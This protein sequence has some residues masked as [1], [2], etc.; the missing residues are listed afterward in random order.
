MNERC[1]SEW[2][3]WNQRELLAALVELRRALAH[4]AGEL[5]ASGPVAGEPAAQATGEVPGAVSPPPAGF[6]SAL[7]TACEAFGLSSF[8]RGL[9]GRLQRVP[10]P[11]AA[12]TF[13][14][15]LGALPNPH[16]SALSPSGPLRRWR[17]IEAGSGDSLTASRLRIDERVLHFLCGVDAPDERLRGLVRRCSLPGPL[18]AAH[19]AAVA[20]VG[21]AWSKPAPHPL[22]QFLGGSATDQRGVAAAAA[23]SLG[24]QLSAM[25]AAEVPATAPEREAVARLWEREAVLTGAVLLLE[26]HDAEPVELTRAAAFLNV[27]GCVAFIAGRDPFHGLEVPTVRIEVPHPP[28]A[29][30]RTMWLEALGPERAAR[31]NG[32]VEAVTQQFQLDAVS[33]RELAAPLAPPGPGRRA[34]WDSCRARTRRPM[35]SLAQRVDA[36]GTWDDLVVP[37]EPR[38]LLG[39]IAAHVR[40]RSRVYEDW[41][42][43]AK[44]TRGLGISALFSG[45]SGTGKTLAAEVLANELHL[46]LFRIDLSAVV[47]KYIGETEKNL[48]RIFDAAEASGAILLFDEAD[49]L[50]GKRSEVR[51]SHDRYANI[52]VGYLLQRI[53]SYRGLAILTTNMRQALD[54]AFLRRLRFIVNFPFPD[55]P[56]RAEIWRKVFPAATPTDGLDAA[57]LARLNVVGG[58]IRNIAL[59]AA[60]L[61][62]DTCEPVRMKHLLHA[63]RSE[64]VKLERP[65]S[66]AELGGWA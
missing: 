21:F 3:D 7:D 59:G 37:P 47:N 10:A 60:V 56:Q 33:I 12:A 66:E 63:A 65:P 16:W 15:A 48:R 31:L 1:L 51:D 13:S 64:C 28:P 4:A 6:R 35:E 18:S 50:F 39:E 52:E 46:D 5:E 27:L 22:V 30:Q 25:R 34:L 42:F 17:L 49:A 23:Q 26:T 61:A 9:L 58:H 44:Q 32:E 57:K 55:A 36:R 53:E 14:V 40:Q 38:R 62:A 41:G 19:A 45:P 29:E 20:R 11:G 2:S 24:L 8:E 54:P 43:A